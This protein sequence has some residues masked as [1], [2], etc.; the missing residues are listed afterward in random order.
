MRQYRLTMIAHMALTPL[1]QL[2]ERGRCT[3]LSIWSLLGN[4]PIVY[5]G[6]QRAE[7]LMDNSARTAGSSVR[8]SELS[9]RLPELSVRPPGS[10]VR[11][12]ELSVRMPEPSVRPP[13]SP[14]RPPE[15]SARLPE[16]SVRLPELSVRMAARVGGS[17]VQPGAPGRTEKSTDHQTRNNAGCI[18]SVFRGRRPPADSCVRGGENRTFPPRTGPR[19]LAPI[20]IKLRTP[21]PDFP[22][23]KGSATP[24]GLRDLDVGCQR[25]GSQTRWEQKTGLVL[26]LIHMRE[27]QT[28]PLHAGGIPRRGRGGRIFGI[29]AI[30]NKSGPPPAPPARKG[31]A[32]HPPRCACGGDAPKGQGGLDLA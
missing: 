16:L 29:V 17:Y 7:C 26:G 18:F 5:R 11:S 14:V 21:R 3:T 27:S 15:L 4:R 6:Y 19:L 12:P 25:R 31:R 13:G 24:A 2:W 1:S 23:R 20:G 10:S 9:A 30:K 32:K 22:A 28:S 8:S